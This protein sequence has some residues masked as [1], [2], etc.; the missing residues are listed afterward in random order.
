[1]HQQ[2][3]VDTGIGEHLAQRL[4]IALRRRV[5]G[6]VDRITAGPHGRQQAIERAQRGRRERASRPPAPISASVAR[7]AG[8]PPL[9]TIASRRRQPGRQRA[10]VSTT[11]KSS[12]V[13]STRSTPARRSAAA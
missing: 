5:A 11:S 8:P 1:M 4:G 7:I 3:R 6:D 9:V 13:V 2:H 10:R 12:R